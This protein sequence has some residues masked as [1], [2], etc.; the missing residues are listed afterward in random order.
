VANHIRDLYAG[1]GEPKSH[2]TP[3]FS[4]AVGDPALMPSSWQSADGKSQQLWT[5]VVDPYCMGCH[6]ISGSDFS[7]YVN[8]AA[9]R[10]DH[11]GKSLLRAYLD[12]DGRDP[13]QPN[14]L[15]YM[16]QSELAYKTLQRDWR[17][18]DAIA[19]WLGGIP[20]RPTPTVG[21][22]TNGDFEANSLTSWRATGPVRTTRRARAGGF[23]AQ[24]GAF[25][26]STE[27]ATLEQTVHV[28]EAGRTTLTFALQPHCWDGTLVAEIRDTT[29]KTL[30]EILRNS[31]E[32]PSSQTDAWT[33]Q[34]VDLTPYAG[35]DVV[36]FFANL[37]GRTGSH[38][39]IDDVRITN[40]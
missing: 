9:L 21:I 17:A 37:P 11:H 22:V 27:D 5:A 13:T 40:D 39:L 7:R 3:P 38:W 35:K 30:R 1:L 32:T 36:L 18:Q 20:P 6:R 23:S 16:P 26:G 31:W 2:S 33:D 28:P 15:P 34:T 14:V 12:D 25:D 19:D 8:F 4:R 10:R 29:T 24:I